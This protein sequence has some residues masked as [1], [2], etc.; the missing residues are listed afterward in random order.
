MTYFSGS[1]CLIFYII[2]D[3]FL[4]IFSKYNREWSK[5][6]IFVIRRGFEPRTDCLEG[7][8][9]IQLSYRTIIFAGAN[10]GNFFDICKFLGKIIR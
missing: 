5:R 9:S 2:Y 1:S 7:S 3:H 4:T 10:I 8:C 6:N